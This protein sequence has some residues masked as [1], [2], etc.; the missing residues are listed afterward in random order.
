M[1]EFEQFVKLSLCIYTIFS[2][3]PVYMNFQ[4]PQFYPKIKVLSVQSFAYSPHVC[5]GFLCFFS[6]F[7]QDYAEFFFILKNLFCVI[8]LPL[9]SKFA[10]LV[11]LQLHFFSA[12]IVGK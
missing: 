9:S 4:Q 1:E 3:F 7:I 2:V 5:M 11:K 8:L 6:R 10:E 12:V